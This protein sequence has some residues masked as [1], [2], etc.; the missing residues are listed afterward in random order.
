MPDA[1]PL[2]WDSRLATA[3]VLHSEDQLAHGTMTHTGSNG[4]LFWERINA[5]GYSFSEAGENVAFGYT[6]TAWVM[7]GWMGS[8]GHC[9]NIMNAQHTDVGMGRAGNYWT[10]DFARRL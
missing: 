7:E 2:T 1:P 4:S 8:A 3:A 9:S 10:Q 6:N 5:A